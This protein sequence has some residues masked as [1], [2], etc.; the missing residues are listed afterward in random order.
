MK[1]KIENENV[2]Y[3]KEKTKILNKDGLKKLIQK[4]K[5]TKNKSLRLCF[6]DN[7]KSNLHQMFIIHPR[8][9]FVPPQYHPSKDESIFVISGKARLNYFK[10]NGK[11]ENKYILDRGNFFHLI[12]KNK[13]HNLEI[14]SSIFI[15]LEI[16]LGPFKKDNTLYP[17]WFKNYKIINKQI[18]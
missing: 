13:I 17:K 18:S 7:K 14:L 3:L 9:Y 15:F 6:H 4:S 2:L 12:K 8:K 11:I 1:I 10:K 16:S 5:K